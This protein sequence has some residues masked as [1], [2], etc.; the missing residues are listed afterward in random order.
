[1]R[2][3]GRPHQMRLGGHPRRLPAAGRGDR[4]A[5][6]RKAGFRP[7]ATVDA[8]SRRHPMERQPARARGGGAGGVGRSA[9][10]APLR[11]PGRGHQPSRRVGALAGRADGDGPAR[12]RRRTVPCRHSLGAAGPRCGDGRRP[13]VADAGGAGVRAAAVER[14]VADRS[15]R[16]RRAARVARRDGRDG[17]AAGRRRRRRR[18]ADDSRRSPVR[19]PRQ[20]P[21]RGPGAADRRRDLG[22]GARRRATGDSPVRRPVRRRHRQPLLSAVP[23]RRGA[24]V[25]LARRRRHRG[26]PRRRREARVLLFARQHP[27]GPR[28]LA[29]RTTVA[30]AAAGAADGR[31]A[32]GGRP[33]HAGRTE[34]RA[35]SLRRDRRHRLPP[36]AGL[37]RARVRPPGVPRSPERRTGPGPG[38]RRRRASGGRPGQRTRAARSGRHHRVG[39]ARRGRG[40]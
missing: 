28:P 10:C 30:R 6:T 25:A 17:V 19:A 26:P 11:R 15:P 21:H 9:L 31:P 36:P 22:A 3:G 20:R 24:P 5:A 1:M 8:A 38:Q 34:P 39:E 32:A 18:A 16:E 27:V 35:Q 7:P 14:G 13:V 33:D 12:G 23:T 29:R 37:L 40:G 2:L 4:P